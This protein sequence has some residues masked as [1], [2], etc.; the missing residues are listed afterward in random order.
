MNRKQKSRLYKIITATVF[1]IIGVVLSKAE[2]MP[3]HLIVFALAAAII[4]YDILISAANGI[5][6]R[7]FLDENFLMALG[8]LGAFILGEFTEGVFLLILYQIGEL[9]QSVAIGKSRKSIN[10]ILNLQPDYANIEE[11]NEIIKVDPYEVLVGS[12][13]IILPGE[14]VPI[15]CVVLEGFSDINTSALTGESMLNAVKPGDKLISGSVNIS[16]TLK[17]KTIKDFENST[18]AKIM[19]LVENATAKKTKAE[20]FITRFAKHYT[21]IVVI[22][23]A[24]LF[25]IPT[26]I[27]GNY[28][29]WLYRSISFL[30][31]SC[32]CALVISVPLAFF[33]AI[34]K[35]SSAGILIKGSQY[36]ET[37]SNVETFVF[38]KTGTLTKGNFKILNVVPNG[39][40]KE[41]LIK[42]AAISE[43]NSPHPIAAAIKSGCDVKEEIK[44]SS[45]H[46]L[47]GGKG[48]IC[49][50]AGSE[51]I[52]GTCTLLA[53]NGIDVPE[54]N[55]DATLVFVAYE[56]KYLGHITI[57]D[58][59]KPNAAEF[60]LALKKAG[61][62]NT[63]ILT[64]DKQ[65]TAN[66]VAKAIG[67]NE[68]HSQLLPQDKVSAL[69]DI[70]K[71]SKGK[72]AYVGDGIN[73]APVLARA[74]IGFSMGNLGSDAAIE[75][76]D[77]VILNDDLNG[78]IKAIKISRKAG[79]ISK[80]NIA[81]SLIIKFAALALSVAGLSTIYMAV[82]ADVGVLIIAILN[83][84]RMLKKDR[85]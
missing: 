49:K 16:A 25:I 52:T 54:I 65:S 3:Y 13:I 80:Q 60:I 55:E 45:E 11:N 81:V 22:S 58:E 83:S 7:H 84:L 63:V 38:D 85:K 67:I 34:G 14:K 1:L 10:E 35:A 33:G 31:V 41:R 72:T 4:G 66:K 29:R 15:D 8:F 57:G 53:E 21:P 12:E 19:E 24:L 68:V 71:K 82:F 36:L 56:N 74:D 9:F 42:L 76:S 32:P 20:R 51:I 75:A 79:R 43:Y 40:T 61:I 64:G 50:Y 59:I 2:Y 70:I 17:A 26:L 18:A 46:T 69:E 28:S 5:L 30:V 23:A 48:V 6:S 78:I 27:F 77:I 73:D 37:L 47:I 39:T 44:L 62:K